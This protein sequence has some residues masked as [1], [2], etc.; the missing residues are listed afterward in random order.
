MIN[1]LRGLGVAVI[2]P[3]LESGEIDF[4]NLEKLVENLIQNGVE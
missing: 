4:S 3:F 2:T 1:R